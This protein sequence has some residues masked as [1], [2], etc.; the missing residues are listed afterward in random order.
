[1]SLDQKTLSAPLS[2]LGHALQSNKIVKIAEILFI[3]LVSGTIITLFIS[4]QAEDLLYNQ[5]VVWCSNIIMLILVFTGVK[6]R[7]ENLRQFG[8]SFHKF[9]LKYALK[10]LLQSVV[11]AVLATAAFV[12]GAVIMANVSGVPAQADHTVYNYISGNIGM[13][14]L[15]LAGVYIVSSF[16]EEIVYRAFLINRISELGVD[17]KTTK[18]IAVILSS[19]IFGLVHYS[20]GFMGIIQTFFMGLV[21]GCS[22]VYLKRKIW[23]LIIAHAYMDTLL[24]VQM[25]LN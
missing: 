11:V 21:L 1:M 13:L 24:M 7:G 23:V 4:E 15:S 10:T 18:I 3:F 14:L 9:T 2:R 12:I 16:G 19:I 20:W 5:F 6:L 22:Y 17:N 25:Y 8:L